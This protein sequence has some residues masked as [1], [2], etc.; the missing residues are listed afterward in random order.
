MIPI[1]NPADPLT[2]IEQIA[3]FHQGP[4]T[5]LQLAA[6][7]LS[8]EGAAR[9]KFLHLCFGGA[10]TV[11]NIGDFIETYPEFATTTRLPKDLMHPRITKQLPPCH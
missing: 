11:H 10:I 2:T 6:P 8:D 5:Y 7:S 1:C 4:A 9:F 3:F